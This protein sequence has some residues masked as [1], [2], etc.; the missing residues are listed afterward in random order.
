MPRI[1]EPGGSYYIPPKPK[2]APAPKT[3][4][5]QSSYWTKKTQQTSGTS[6]W[7]KIK[8]RVTQAMPNFQLGTFPQTVSNMQTAGSNWRQGLN[9][10]Y[11]YYQPGLIDATGQSPIPPAT[12][13]YYWPNT[14]QPV[15]GPAARPDLYPQ[16]NWMLPLPKAQP[17]KAPAVRAGQTPAWAQNPSQ[18]F[19]SGIN[20]GPEKPEN[21]ESEAYLPPVYGGGGGWGGWGG[22]GG[23]SSYNSNP[24]Y[25]GEAA[26]QKPSYY[27]QYL[28]WRVK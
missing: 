3:T 9:T 16:F 25:R 2:P 26:A 22:G 10:G 12:T 5:Q 18:W 13:T 17:S 11:A 14:L 21:M 19:G 27:A 8:Q 28:T 24:F 23:S 20:M 1:T 4:T 15:I 6:W 7:E